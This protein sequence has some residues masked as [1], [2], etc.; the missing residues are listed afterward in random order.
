MVVRIRDIM[1]SPVITIRKNAK[2][3]EAVSAMCANNI[4]SLVVVDREE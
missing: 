1:T 3:S 4:G 2:A